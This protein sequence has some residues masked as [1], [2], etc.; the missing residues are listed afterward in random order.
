MIQFLPGFKKVH[1]ENF[2]EG[3]DQRHIN[4]HCVCSYNDK[5]SYCMIIK[6]IVFCFNKFKQHCYSD[7]FSNGSEIVVRRAVSKDARSTISPKRLRGRGV[8]T[9]FQRNFIKENSLFFLGE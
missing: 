1:E 9:S 7:L 4:S 8:R 5:D 6:C 2:H 3:K